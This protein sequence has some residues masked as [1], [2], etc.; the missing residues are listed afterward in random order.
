FTAPFSYTLIFPLAPTGNPI[1][2]DAFGA[3]G[4]I[5]AS[6]LSNT[7]T[8][9]AEEVTING[10]VISG[11]GGL[12]PDSD[13]NGSSGF[14]LPQLWDDT[15]HDISVVRPAVAPVLSV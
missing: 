2:F 5:G 12:D 10:T 8:I 14:P 6:R 9:A 3:D 1:L 13:W 4:Q 7:G 15:G 11:A